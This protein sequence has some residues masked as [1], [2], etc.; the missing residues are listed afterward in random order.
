MQETVSQQCGIVQAVQRERDVAIA[1]LGRHGLTEY[2]QAA[3]GEGVAS[4]HV[5]DPRDHVIQ[6]LRQRNEELCVV[7]RQMRSEMEEITDW[8]EHPTN[9]ITDKEHGQVLTHGY[10][11]YME[12]EVLRLKTESRELSERLQEGRKPPPSGDKRKPPSPRR[13]SQHRSHLIALSD[14]IASL[15]RE[16]QGMEVEALQLRSELEEKEKTIAAFQEQ[17]SSDLAQPLASL[18]SVLVRGVVLNGGLPFRMALS[19]WVVVV[20]YIDK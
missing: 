7:I 6:Q 17:V 14:T 20:A 19:F 2:Y 13:E 1:T 5:T 4:S 3:C 10:V 8:S 16:R 9:H 12:N 15:Q 18:F 11:K